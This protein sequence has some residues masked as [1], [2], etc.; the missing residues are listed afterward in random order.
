MI[1]STIS[2]SYPRVWGGIALKTLFWS[3]MSVL[4]LSFALE[5]S[6]QEFVRPLRLR[7]LY[8]ASFFLRL[9]HLI[10]CTTATQLFPSYTPPECRI[11]TSPL[12]DTIQSTFVI[13]LPN[14]MMLCEDTMTVSKR[15]TAAHNLWGLKIFDMVLHLHCN[16][17][18]M[19]PSNRSPKTA[20]RSNN[21]SFNPRRY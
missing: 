5:W 1:C 2:Y 15:Q 12:S 3:L 17:S 6:D 9:S 20:Y 19:P 4:H 8:V 11:S 18:P 10:C 7:P 14:L 16:L 13:R 21:V